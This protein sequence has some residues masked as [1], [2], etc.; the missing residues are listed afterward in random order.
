MNLSIVKFRKLKPHEYYQI[1]MYI[2]RDY[3]FYD[4][5]VGEIIFN[6]HLRCYA[7][8]NYSSIFSIRAHI[9][10][11]TIFLY[12]C[13]TRF[14]ANTM[15]LKFCAISCSYRWHWVIYRK[16]ILKMSVFQ[17]RHNFVSFPAGNCL[18]DSS[19]EGAYR[20]FVENII[21]LCEDHEKQLWFCYS[22]YHF[23]SQE[24]FFYWT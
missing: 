24:L 19:W 4:L 20:S 13:P 3:N 6:S 14:K 22:N 16:S 9:W 8:Q 10:V 12:Y 15:P 5:V 17:I 23:W 7:S 18:N 11:F 2:Y 21:F 1:Y